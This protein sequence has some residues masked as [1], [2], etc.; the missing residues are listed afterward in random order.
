MTAGDDR[1]RLA[2]AGPS[3]QRPPL[4]RAPCLCVALRR[5]GRS[6]SAASPLALRFCRRTL[7]PAG[8]GASLGSSEPYRRA[9][10]RSL[11]APQAG[12]VTPGADGQQRS[13]GGRRARGFLRPLRPLSRSR[14][15]E[16]EA[17][18]P[19]ERRRWRQRQGTRRWRAEAV[20]EGDDDQ[21]GGRC[22]GGRGPGA[23]ATT[24][25]CGRGRPAPGRTGPGRRRP[26]CP[27]GRPSA[28]R[29][30]LRRGQGRLPPSGRVRGALGL[31]R[32]VPGLGLCPPRRPP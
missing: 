13:G 4:A 19:H 22:C 5:L 21:R 1:A 2:F 14:T 18:V 7:K 29:G 15:P 12:P 30:R 9:P 24:G 3:T 20:G 10:R 16:K 26:L 17:R 8:G 11:R 25:Q 28:L 31:E 6:P 27:R 32:P 23:G